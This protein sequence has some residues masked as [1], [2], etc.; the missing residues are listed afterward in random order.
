NSPVWGQLFEHQVADLLVGARYVATPSSPQPIWTGCCT[1]A[2][3][4]LSLATAIVCPRK[5]TRQCNPRWGGCPARGRH[6]G[7]E[8]PRWH[9]SCARQGRQIRPP[10]AGQR[11]AA[12]R[13]A[14]TEGK[15]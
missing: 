14:G 8:A 5:G 12:D 2:M 10:T 4:S 3:S 13:G 7:R 1:A 6:H 15:R 9:C 11:Q